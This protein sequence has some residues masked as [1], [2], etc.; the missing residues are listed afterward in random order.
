MDFKFPKIPTEKTLL[1]K[2]FRDD[3]QVENV[4]K[5]LIAIV[6]AILV[7]T[8]T[9][10]LVVNP[11]SLNVEKNQIIVVVIT[12]ILNSF[13]VLVYKFFKSSNSKKQP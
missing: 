13:S 4:I 5:L 8:I 10:S 6:L 1:G 3:K 12:T 7:I 11:E 2:F 9:F